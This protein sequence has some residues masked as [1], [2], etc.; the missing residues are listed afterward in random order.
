VPKGRLF[1]LGRD[2]LVECLALVRA[3]RDGRLDRVIMPR[4]PLDILSQQIVAAVAC[5]DWDEDGLFELCRRAYPYRDLARDDYDAI[6]EMLSEGIAPQRS[7][8]GAYIHRDRV[9]RRLHARRGARMTAITCGGA[10]P[11]VADY[12]VVTDDENRTVVGT[13]DEDFAIESNSGDIFL[14]GNTSWRVKYIRGGEVVVSDAHGAPPTVPFWLGE[15]PGRTF[16]LSAEVSRLR[17]GIA[18]RHATSDY[19]GVI[20]W[21]A[22]VC[23]VEHH[24][25][26]Q[27]VDF[28]AA[29]LA[30]T[31]MV[32]TQ[33]KLL[34]ERFFDES[35]GMQ[36]VM[37]APW[38]S[39]INRAWG[40]AMRKRF[41]RSFD[42]ELQASADD[43]G[44]VLS[45][46]AQH[47]FP[48]EQMF[49]LVPSKLARETLIQAFLAVPTFTT[50]WRWNVTRALQMK[51]SSKGTRVLPHL[52]RMRSDDLLSAVFPAQTA[53]QENVVGD[54]EL[55]DHPLIRQTVD[56]CLFEASD[57]DGLVKVLRQIESGEIEIVGLDSREPSPMAASL[58]NANVY[59]FLDDAPLEER[60]ARAVTMRRSLSVEA[61]GDL[62]KLDPAAIAQVRADAW[63]L[64]RDADELHDTLLSMGSLS[65]AD[66][67]P[68]EHYFA[69]LRSTGRATELTVQQAPFWVATERRALTCAAWPQAVARPQVATPAGVRA[70]WTRDEAIAYLVRGRMECTGPTTVE[71]LAGGLLLP[72][73][74]VEQ[75]ML[76]LENQGTVLRGR[77]TQDTGLEWCDRRLLARIH[78]LTL[79]GLRRQ[80]APAPADQFIRFLVRHQHAGPRT[81]L[82]GQAGL[83]ALIEQFEGFEAPA[84]HWERY[85]FPS[86]LDDYDPA[87]LDLLT[88]YGQ[89][90][91]GRLRNSNPKS[92]IENPKSHRRR[93]RPMKALTRSTPIALMLRDDLPWLL[94]TSDENERP[95]RLS[96]NAELAYRTFQQHGALF[97]AQLGSMIDL[98]PSQVEDVLGELGAAG[99]VTSDGYPSLRALVAQTSHKQKRHGLRR[100]RRIAAPAAAMGRWSLLRPPSALAGPSDARVENWCRLLLNRYGVMFRDL[101]ANESAAPPWQELVRTYRRLEARGEIRGGRF[102]AGV[103]G[104]Q[105]AL[106]EVVARLRA[107]EDSDERPLVLPATDPLNFTGRISESP[108]VPA[109]P[110]HT[111]MIV[112][113]ELQVAPDERAQRRLFVPAPPI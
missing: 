96:G 22:Q 64:V 101:L 21:V 5:E 105:Y 78:R 82:R 8:H 107:D 53:C 7:R 94:P 1:A 37:H 18:A 40:L 2:D 17:E 60:R 58:L 65:A 67:R 9:N 29:Q 12:R 41:C 74:E 36:L 79:E 98:L 71:A 95:A 92:K 23:H 44:I 10:I 97:P 39:R 47:S 55:P 61:I 27:V 56:D 49:R 3:V 87:W 16:E 34:F 48:L 59:A 88:F 83:L 72:P 35:G 69:E 30:A 76:A 11:E 111:V 77:F 93:A 112:R 62:A 26:K 104:E 6:L 85:L 102:V 38:G 25:A 108:R 89:V 32:P 57:I 43:N 109:L 81:K 73:R 33:K 66:G 28:V 50:R 84:G 19:T 68:W 31:G 99:L 54:I 42:F 24:G 100:K 106:S 110:G 86:R 90:T 75:A 103:A 45:L 113:G 52:Q 70:E 14:L 4:A 20:D 63:P 91:W 46:G 13:L 51:R 15:A 80:I